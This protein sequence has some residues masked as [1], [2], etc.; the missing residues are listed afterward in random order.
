MTPPTWMLLPQDTPFSFSQM[1]KQAQGARQRSKLAEASRSPAG[2]LSY[3]ASSR[4]ASSPGASAGTRFPLEG[5]G[6]GAQKRQPWG[7]AKGS[8]GT[9]G[10]SDGKRRG[11]GQ[12]GGVRDAAG[13]SGHQPSNG[14]SGK[15]HSFS[16]GLSGAHKASGRETATRGPRGWRCPLQTNR[17]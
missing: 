8:R 13:S 7:T 15:M 14:G 16:P 4:T 12:G 10:S 11:T 6:L 17:K 3:R 2:G 9:I 5:Q 1:R